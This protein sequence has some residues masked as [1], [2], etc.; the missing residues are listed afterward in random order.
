MESYA[1]RLA[2]FNATHPATKK[3]DSNTRGAKTLKWPYKSPT[4]PDVS[5]VV[6]ILPCTNVH[7][8]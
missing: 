5:Y 8:A 2:S 4:P 7:K 6:L 1:A 3:R